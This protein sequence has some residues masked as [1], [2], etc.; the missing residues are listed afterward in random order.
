MIKSMFGFL[1]LEGDLIVVDRDS[2]D[3]AIKFEE[4]MKEEMD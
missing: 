2:L 1:L 3:E 4:Q